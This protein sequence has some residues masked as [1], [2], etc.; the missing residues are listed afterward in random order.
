ME[1][2][3]EITAQS[4]KTELASYANKAYEC[5]FEYV[6]NSLDAGA[7]SID[8]KYTIPSAGI[9]RVED[10][11][12]IDNGRGWNFESNRVHKP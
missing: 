10:V 5:L 3:V 11:E 6:W 12:L 9:G 8:I 4:I 7:T 2:K 1:R